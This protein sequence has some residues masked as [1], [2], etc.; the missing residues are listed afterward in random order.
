MKLSGPYLTLVGGLA[1]GGVLLALS[2]TAVD[3]SQDRVANAAASTPRDAVTTPPAETAPAETPPAETASPSADADDTAASNAQ[4]VLV[5]A[6]TYAGR[7]LSDKASVAVSVK[8]KTAIAYFCDGAKI[9]A[10]VQG[11][12]DGSPLVLKGK[13][14]AKLTAE[15]KNGRLIGKV[16]AGGKDWSFNIKKVKAPSGLYRAAANVRSAKVVGGWIIFEGRQIGMLESSTD[17][18][19]PAPSIDLET[20]K[21]TI[22]GTQVQTEQ[23]DG[24]P[25]D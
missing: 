22:D 5:P 8:G 17:G 9:E 14:G 10:W 13:K 25:G 2:S 1:V 4:E 7:E 21:V 6:G 23:L 15:Y 3:R 24:P 19:V 18:E 12:A 11:P 20:G 16:K